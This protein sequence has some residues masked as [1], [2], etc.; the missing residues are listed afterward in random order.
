MAS[1]RVYPSRPLGTIEYFVVD[2]DEAERIRMAAPGTWLEIG[3]FHVRA[4]H[5]IA[6]RPSPKARKSTR[7]RVISPGIR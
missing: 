4:E 3:H 5:I 1:Y 6:I 2:A 7:A